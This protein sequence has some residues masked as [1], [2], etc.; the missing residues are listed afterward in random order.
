M[1][2]KDIKAWGILLTLLWKVAG[3]QAQEVASSRPNS[4][5][6]STIHV[7]FGKMPKRDILGAVSHVDVASLMEKNYATHSLD[8]LQSFIGGYTGSVWGQTPLILIDGIPRRAEDVR[9]V[10][11]ES[12][13]IL[14]D[15]SSVAL[16]GS[17]GSKGAVLINT[18]RGS[19]KPLS[20]D[21]RANT[22]LL[23]PKRYPSYLNAAEY[24]TLYNEASRNDGLTERYSAEAIYNTSLGSNPYRYPDLNLFS[25][26]Y[27]KKYA[28]RSDVTAEISGGNDRA[29]YYTNLGMTHVND[30]LKLGEAKNNKD[31]SFNIR[32][33]VDV[34]LTKWLKASTDAVAIISDNNYARG[35]F[36]A[37]TANLRPNHDGFAP[38]VP[39]DRLDLSNPDLQAIVQNSNHII[40]GKYLLGGLSNL[41]TNDLSQ[42]IASGYIKNKNRTFLFNVGA[43]AD[44]SGLTPGLSFS[45]RYSM[46]YTTRYTE[47]YNVPYATYQPHWQTIDGSEIITSLTKFGNDGNSTNEF[48][49][50]ALYYQTMSI[51]SQF[52]YE[53]T[54]NEHHHIHGTLLGWGYMRQFSSDVDTNQGGSDYQPFRNTNV[55]IQLG[56][57]YKQRYYLDASGAVVHSAKLP[58]DN[59]RALSP[60]V[61]VGW[62]ISEETFFKNQASFVNDLKLTASYA[63]LKQDLDITDY[64]LYRENYGNSTAEGALGAWYQWRDGGTTGGGGATVLAGRGAN[65]NLSFVERREFRVGLDTWLWNN[66]LQ[67]NANYFRQHT[68]GLLTRGNATIFPSYFL[69]GNGEF[70]PW[71]NFNNDLRTGVDFSLNIISKIGQ[72]GY[73]LG[74]VGMFYDT[75]ATQRDEVYE[76][77]YQY[78]TGR[79]IDA[80]W[81]YIAEGLFQNEDDI[82]T[83]ARQN[84]GGELKPGDIK[85]RDVNGDGIIDTRDQVDLGRNGFA[86]NPFSYGLNL[87]VK[88]KNFTIFALGSGHTGGLGFKNNPYFW[89]GGLTKYSTVVLDRWTEETASTATYPRLTTTGSSNNFQNS[90]YWSFKTNRFNLNRV[91]LTY[92][93]PESLFDR[94]DVI[95]RMNI[96]VNGDNLLVLS[97]E[98]K[99]LETNFGSAPQMRFYNLGVKA[100]F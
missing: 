27:I 81:G 26:E 8:N 67:L 57:H 45:T 34:N 64:Y 25:D 9:M 47:G 90:T 85:Y 95:N 76:N 80:S 44:L 2:K 72:L 24:M 78:R 10:E 23:V 75:K 15:A 56:Y 43:D 37:A 65:P 58:M 36:W 94:S 53:R 31:M 74:F 69:Q 16:Y 40:D 83:H 100:F 63:S 60:S 3:L 61:T 30:I 51:T 93:L 88:W 22:G 49:G 48:I 32:T 96:Y 12:I 66:S 92:D 97:N 38:F 21:I 89:V 68:N 73:S 7:A 79:P 29:R 59:R 18:R 50:T 5:L 20:I 52:N 71:L 13:T 62:R 35:N 33:N 87:T 28:S 1:M 55:G 77:S 82:R 17:A 70:L 39:I 99:M 14:K 19:I 86:A 84:F 4:A 98:R 42:M 91:Q 6:D 46:D 11:I 41:Q 54:F